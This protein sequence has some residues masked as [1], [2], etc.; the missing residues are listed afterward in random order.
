MLFFI[1]HQAVGQ[2]DKI[3]L[4][5]DSYAVNGSLLIES[6]DGS[7]RYDYNVQAKDS[8]LPAST[9]K[10]PN[11]LIILE[12]GLIDA[13]KDIIRW[14]G[15]QREVAQWNQDQT[16]KTAF[17]RSCVWCYQH[18]ALQVGDKK[19]RHYLHQ[20]NYGNQLTG[21]E[22]TR[23]WLDGDLRISVDDQVHFLRKLYKDDL[24]VD[25]KHIKT[26]K[27][28]MLSDD[29]QDYK[30][31]SKTGW[32]GKNGWFVGY[33]SVGAKV[34]LFAH[35]IEINQRSDLALRKKITIES[36]KRLGIIQ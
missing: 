34:W 14:D 4:L 10:I 11:T 29:N 31:W 16:L 22:L 3:R 35:Y 2:D 20:F 7:V 1:S 19:Y 28:I 36:F 17:Q 26:L 13:Q 27:A 32:S 15:K 5:Y 23:F 24:P 21:P 6:I 33:L 30:I 9:F 12:E 18:F 25:K 8:Y